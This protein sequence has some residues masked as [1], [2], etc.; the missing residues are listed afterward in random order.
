MLGPSWLQEHLSIQIFCRHWVYEAGDWGVNSWLTQ[1]WGDCWLFFLSCTVPGAQLWFKSHFSMRA[2]PKLSAPKATL[3]YTSLSW[4]E[5][6]KMQHCGW[7]QGSPG[8]NGPTG[9]PVSIG[10]RK[11]AQGRPFLL[12]PGHGHER[13]SPGR[14]PSYCSGKQGWHVGREGAMAASP[15]LAFN[16]GM[17][18][19]WQSQFPPQVFPVIDFLTPIHFLRLSPCSQ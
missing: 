9:E 16:H 7:G 11:L 1:L 3:E 8:S 15:F 13:A 10:T 19:L 17:L 6:A 4:W 5:W 2:Y 12:A 18:F 14:G